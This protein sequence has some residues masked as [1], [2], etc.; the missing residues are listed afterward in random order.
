MTRND[1]Y[2]LVGLI[3]FVFLAAVV[4]RIGWEIGEILVD[5]VLG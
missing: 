2:I 4:A 5:A 3:Q 1:K